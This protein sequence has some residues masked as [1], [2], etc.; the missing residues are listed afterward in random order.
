MRLGIMGIKNGL[1]NGEP[2]GPVAWRETRFNYDFVCVFVCVCHICIATIYMC[3]SIILYMY[4]GFSKPFEL[5]M[6]SNHMGRPHV[7]M[8]SS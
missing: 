6:D 2:G 7:D 8:M 4:R 5:R 3:I 1:L